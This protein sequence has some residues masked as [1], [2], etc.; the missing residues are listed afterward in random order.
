MQLNPRTGGGITGRRLGGLP[1]W[2]AATLAAIALALVMVVTGLA[3]EA[4]SDKKPPMQI[5]PPGG[6][7]M[8]Q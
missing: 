1:V 8:A 7:Q 5:S 3:L 6:H 4:H 2:V